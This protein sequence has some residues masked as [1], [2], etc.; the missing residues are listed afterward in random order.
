MIWTIEVYIYVCVDLSNS[1]D[2]IDFTVVDTTSQ[3]AVQSRSIV[4]DGHHPDRDD[5]LRRLAPPPRRESSSLAENGSL[6]DSSVIN[7]CDGS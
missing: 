2:A 1:Q 7:T 5:D 4:V 6:P 3:R